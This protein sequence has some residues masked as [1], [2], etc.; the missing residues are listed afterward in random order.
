MKELYSFM[1]ECGN[2]HVINKKNIYRME[3]SVQKVCNTHHSVDFN[4]TSRG[5]RGYVSQ[6][7]WRGQQQMV[8]C[9]LNLWS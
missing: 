8:R 2:I 5:W 3:K 4:L 1:Q 7:Y 6:C 9:G